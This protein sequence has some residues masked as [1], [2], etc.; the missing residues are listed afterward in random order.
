MT[1]GGCQEESDIATWEERIRRMT[2]MSEGM[3]AGLYDDVLEY[4]DFPTAKP[5]TTLSVKWCG[6]T[7]TCPT[8]S[9]SRAKRASGNDVLIVTHRVVLPT[10][11]AADP[12]R[13]EPEP[14]QSQSP[15][16]ARQ[17]TRH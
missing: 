13:Y 12:E 10:E 11:A 5:T 1:I 9:S 6:W 7:P 3:D 15:N 17:P 2:Q 14:D 16:R 8:G 4:P